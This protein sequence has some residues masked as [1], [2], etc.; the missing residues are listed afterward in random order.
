MED[1]VEGI[2]FPEN[3]SSQENLHVLVGILGRL[4]MRRNRGDRE[5]TDKNVEQLRDLSPESKAYVQVSRTS[6]TP[7][8]TMR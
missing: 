2:R 7:S 6:V 4:L 8:D 1:F 3:P 5:L